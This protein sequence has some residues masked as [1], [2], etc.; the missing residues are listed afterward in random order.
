MYYRIETIRQNFSMSHDTYILGF[1][2]E[3]FSIFVNFLP[4]VNTQGV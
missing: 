2:K 1:Y 3:A 4:L